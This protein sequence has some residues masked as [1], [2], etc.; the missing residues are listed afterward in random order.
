[1]RY[2]ITGV[3]GFIGSHLAE[4]LLDAGH[5][6]VGMDSFVPYYPRPIKERNESALHGRTGYTFHEADLRDADLAPLLDGVDVVYHIAAMAGLLKSWTE[7]DIYVSCNINATHRLLEA[8]RDAS[9][10]QFIHAS[11]SSVYGKYVIGPEDS[12]PQPVSPYGI[13]KLAAEHLVNTFNHQFGLPTTILR[14][15][16]VYGPRQRPDMGYQIFVDK[17]LRG[18]TITIFGDG[19]QSRAN[20]YVKDIVQGAVKATEKFQSGGVYNLG[21]VEEVNVIDV[22]RLIE[23]LADEEARIEFGPS[24]PGEQSRAVADITRAREHLGYEPSTTLRDGLSAQI[25][26]HRAWLE[27]QG[28]I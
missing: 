8:S 24:R 3:A 23:E 6:V 13:T 17:I 10:S 7:F 5:E 2:L 19:K 22:I 1:M 9:V 18:E 21:G 27:S 12:L 25:K 20:T 14:F 15:F 4:S 11:T 16:S 26:W 28:E